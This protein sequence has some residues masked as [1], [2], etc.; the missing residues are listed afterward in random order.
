MRFFKAEQNSLRYTMVGVA[1]TDRI[2]RAKFGLH[3]PGYRR[4][5]A[6]VSNEYGVL[7]AELDFYWF[8]LDFSLGHVPKRNH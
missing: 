6:S 8:G 3:G 7:V 2:L 4:L 5:G 1:F